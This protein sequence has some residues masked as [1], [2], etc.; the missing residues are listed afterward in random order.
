MEPT[1]YARSEPAAAERAFGEAVAAF[2]AEAF[3]LPGLRLLWVSPADRAIA[4]VDACL[5][6]TS[7]A[8]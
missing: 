3:V 1:Y 6:Y 4:A 8:A 5:L 7:D 2:V